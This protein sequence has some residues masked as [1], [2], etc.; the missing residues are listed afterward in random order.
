MSN[1]IEL[2]PLHDQIAI[3]LKERAERSKGG[4]YI[5]PNAKDQELAW[6]A[7][8]VAVGPGRIL[9]SGQRVKPNVSVGDT[10]VLGKYMGT[11]IR[12]KDEDY[13]IVREEHILGIVET[14][15]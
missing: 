1:S 5:P 7:D 11:E 14:D 12:L 15:G 3:K 9:E 10:V 6:L 4:I 2:R 13:I 8:V